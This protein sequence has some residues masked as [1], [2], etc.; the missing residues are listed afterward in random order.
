[1][2]R[3]CLL[4]SRLRSPFQPRRKE[5]IFR[6]SDIHRLFYHRCNTSYENSNV[7]PINVA[8]YEDFCTFGKTY[9]NIYVRTLKATIF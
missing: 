6:L 8:F 5:R 4:V 7:K 3:L 9:F 2:V 1:M